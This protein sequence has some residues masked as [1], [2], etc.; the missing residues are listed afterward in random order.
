MVQAITNEIENKKIKIPAYISEPVTNQSEVLN[1]YAE[2]MQSMIAMIDAY[3]NRDEEHKISNKLRGKSITKEIYHIDYDRSVDGDTPVLLLRISEKKKGFTDLTVEGT[4]TSV[5]G[6][7]DKLTTQYN[8][9]VLY[10]N[11]D[12]RGLELS[13]NWVTFVYVDPGKTDTD[14]ISTVKMT[15]NRILKLKIKNVKSSAAN[16]LIRR[17]GLIPKLTAQYVVVLNNE[18]ESLDI[19]GQMISST[20]KEIKKFEYQ[21]IPAE[22]VEEY[23]NSQNDRTYSE[24]KITLS[25][26]DSQEL[27][28]VHK[29]DAEQQTLL[30][31]IEQV[32]N[33]EIEILLADF[34][35]MYDSDFILRQVR[36]AALQFYS[37]NE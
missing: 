15:L 6:R 20:V 25:F 21:D 13:N 9:A 37:P 23:V 5:V 31:A 32:Y 16:A 34:P 26:A 29:Q 28:Y 24:R 18:N 22:D 10:P 2:M 27:K 4:N 14:V 1:T 7:D 12:N 33:Y 11:I 30:D 3:N 19:R 36:D 8:C 35:R 17:E